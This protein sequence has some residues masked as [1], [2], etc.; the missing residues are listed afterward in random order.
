[1]AVQVQAE[2][3]ERAIEFRDRHVDGTVHSAQVFA[4]GSRLW[5]GHQ[6]SSSLS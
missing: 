5:F 2:L 3:A 6:S 4:L 1:V